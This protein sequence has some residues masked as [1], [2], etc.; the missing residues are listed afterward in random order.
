MRGYFGIGAEG[1]S[2]PMNLGALWRTGHAFGASFLFTV[3][4][5]HKVRE[6]VKADTS[7]SVDHVP[8]HVWNSPAEMALP[9]NCVLVGV[10][11][12]DDAVDLPVFKHPLCAAY[13]LGRERGSLSPEMIARCSSVVKIPTKFSLNVSLAG[14]L[15]LYDRMLALGGYGERGGMSRR[16]ATGAKIPG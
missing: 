13:V 14:A 7:R 15:V 8:V 6:I 16:P 2:K 4:A 1:I 12:T 10:E 9:H 3:N 5:H 11:L